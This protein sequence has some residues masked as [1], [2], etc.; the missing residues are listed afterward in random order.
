LEGD[1]DANCFDV[2]R[3]LLLVVGLAIS[4]AA[5]GGGPMSETEYVEA[6]NDL[7]MGAG[8]ELEASLVA[9]Q[10]I[11]EPT[12]DDFVTHIEQQLAVEYQVRDKFEALDP[13]E[14]I[15]AVNQIMV[16]V[17]FQILAAA[18]GLIAVADTLDSLEELEQT[19]EFAEY[20]TV[21][22]DA[23]SM[24]LDVQ[25]EFDDLMSGPVINDPWLA[26]LQLTVRGFVN[27]DDVA[28]G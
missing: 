27:C 28:T 11:D 18:E 22:A 9:Y 19:Q 8:P 14:S 25:A 10:Q 6:L 20:Q 12:L 4:I 1:V 26:D 3:L 23:E 13:P 7:V 16:D 17:L 2:R 15:E 24:C 21:N 5:C